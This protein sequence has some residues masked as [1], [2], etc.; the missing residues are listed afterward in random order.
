MNHG[1]VVFEDTV[2]HRTLLREAGEYAAAADAD[3][4]LLAFLDEE[5]YEADLE[6]LESVGRVENVSYGS[7]AIMDAAVSDIRDVAE[8]VLDGLDVEF[9]IAVAVAEDD[10]RAKRVIN[11]GDEYDCDHAF[12]VGK[13]RSPTGKAIF[14][15]FAQR[16]ILNFDGYVTTATN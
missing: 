15:D 1:L 12:I 5:S 11:A 16:V 13:S 6:T 4:L 14:G 7:D 8:D 10:E 3:L 2:T 9:D